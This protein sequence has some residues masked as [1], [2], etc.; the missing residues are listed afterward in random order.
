MMWN[1]KSW[2]PILKDSRYN[3]WV[4][5]D[6]G[7]IKNCVWDNRHHNMEWISYFWRKKKLAKSLFEQLDGTY[8]EE[9]WVSDSRFKITYWR[10][11]VDRHMVT[12]TFGLSEAVPQN[13]IHQSSHKRH[14]EYLPCQHQQAGTETLWKAHRGNEKARMPR[15]KMP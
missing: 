4:K 5:P 11:T 14:A 15:K 13:Y 1:K 7:K 6:R 2:Q 10:R 12:A 8:H 9:K 3:Q